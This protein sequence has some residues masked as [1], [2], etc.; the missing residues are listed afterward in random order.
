MTKTPVNSLTFLGELV[1]KQV[2]H[3]FGKSGMSVI[4]FLIKFT[5]CADPCF[6]VLSLTILMTSSEFVS[7][8]A[9]TTSSLPPSAPRFCPF[10]SSALLSSWDHFPSFVLHFT[11]VDA[12][13]LRKHCGFHRAC[14]APYHGLFCGPLIA[15]L[16]VPLKGT[17]SPVPPINA[18]RR[19]IHNQDVFSSHSVTHS[20]FDSHTHVLAHSLTHSFFTLLYFSHYCIHLLL[21]SLAHSVTHSLHSL[22][23]LFTHPLVFHSLTHTLSQYSIYSHTHSSIHSLTHSSTHSSIHSLACLCLLSFRKFTNIVDITSYEHMPHSRCWT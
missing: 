5:V 8:N 17:L 18:V 16:P 21:H 3:T 15:E 14:S 11:S 13:F 4:I 23:H 20:R 22:A 2:I 1:T 7:L 9:R 19:L 10:Q 12:S 6:P